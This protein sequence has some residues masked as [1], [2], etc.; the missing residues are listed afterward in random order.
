MCAPSEF[1]SENAP[2]P[3]ELTAR[4]FATIK[5]S[6]YRLKGGETTTLIG[7]TQASRLGLDPRQ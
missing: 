1:G 4:T 5:L 2:L 3:K 7:T 6:N